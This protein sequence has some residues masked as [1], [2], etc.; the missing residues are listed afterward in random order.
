MGNVSNRGLVCCCYIALLVSVT[1][2]YAAVGA[3][4]C[5]TY[6]GTT[7]WL[8]CKPRLEQSG[9]Y[10][11][12]LVQ[13]CY[14]GTVEDA[15]YP[16]VPP[17]DPS[18]GGS[19][20]VKCKGTTYQAQAYDDCPGGG[21]RDEEGECQTTCPEAGTEAGWYRARV[22]EVDDGSYTS[23]S[24]GGCLVTPSAQVDE[25][26]MI[27]GEGDQV[28]CDFFYNH[29]GFASESGTLEPAGGPS[30]IGGRDY[31]SDPETTSLKN[32][33]PKTTTADHPDPGDETTEQT[34]TETTNAGGKNEVV[35][36][37]TH[38][39]A[40]REGDRVTVE[41]VTKTTTRHPDGSE[42]ITEERNVVVTTDD[43]HT[44]TI[45]KNDGSVTSTTQPGAVTSGT[46][47]RTT[48]V[49]A[50]GTVTETETTTGNNEVLDDTNQDGEKD[51]NLPER[52]EGDDIGGAISDAWQRVENAPIVQA[53]EN[54]APSSHQAGVCPPLSFSLFGGSVSTTFHCEVWES[55]AG[56]L[57]VASFIAWTLIGVFIVASA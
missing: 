30:P 34:T 17:Q 28:W 12:G 33:G 25:C 11:Q 13:N 43:T 49:N 40:T 36:T 47:T 24:V 21:I 48:E 45:D 41:T 3:W 27:G 8:A 52:G 18:A 29:T 38:V 50:D 35:S 32:E 44:T 26:Y 5:D 1:P 53:F 31:V 15:C 37:E 46:K 2:G 51:F 54:V 55:I 42:T 19:V 16:L 7:P 9:K 6:T 14:E 56:V 4:T 20:D 22:E 39:T 57:A 10:C 23:R